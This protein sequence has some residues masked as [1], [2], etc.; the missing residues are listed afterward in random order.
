MKNVFET[1]NIRGFSVE[2]FADDCA[3]E[4][5]LEWSDTVLVTAH[6]R[7]DFGGI[8]LPF[9]AC[10]IEDA[11]D[12]H[13]ADNGLERRDVIWKP[14]YL[15]DHSGYALSTSPFGDRWDSGQLGFIYVSRANIR[16]EFG[17]KRI[18]AKLEQRMIMRLQTELELVENWLNGEIYGYHIPALDECCGGFFSC[19]HDRSG[20]IA[21]A[22]EAID[23]EIK[24]RRT[25]RFNKLKQ[26]VRNRVPLNRRAD[27]LPAMV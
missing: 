24:R 8:R 26:L 11:F 27:I 7:S 23:Y 6:R 17:I 19:D 21:A 1:L 18:S 20:L 10:S 4:N 16:Q 14:V 15:Y 3:T 5:P 13:L 9:D 2:I 25:K 12:E 22:T